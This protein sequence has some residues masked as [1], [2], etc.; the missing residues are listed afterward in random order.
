MYSLLLN[1][2]AYQ[3]FSYAASPD[4]RPDNFGDIEA[5]YN[6]FMGSSNNDG[7]FSAIRRLEVLGQR[8][9]R[10]TMLVEYYAIMPVKAIADI[11]AMDYITGAT[12]E[13]MRVEIASEQATLER[14]LADFKQEHPVKEQDLEANR[15]QVADFF[16]TIE[17]L[18]NFR[19][20][21][22]DPNMILMQY[23]IAI[24]TVQDE[25]TKANAK[26]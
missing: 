20:R 9:R 22:I 11:L 21:P 6:A 13:V 5:E 15:A 16:Q 14:L 3:F 17:D 25:I 8:I 4:T 18:S 1:I 24:R 12:V 7:S 19:K 10:L 23:C 26:A 2:T